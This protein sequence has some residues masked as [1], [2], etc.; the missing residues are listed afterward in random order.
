MAY[1]LVDVSLDAL[2]PC[3]RIA[4][5]V[6]LL[7]TCLSSWTCF[8]NP[9]CRVGSRSG[10]CSYQSHPLLD[11]SSC[12]G[13]YVLFAGLLYHYN[14]RHQAIENVLKEPQV[15]GSAVAC[16][17]SCRRVEALLCLSIIR[18]CIFGYCG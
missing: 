6:Y 10:A 9:G 11:L 15:V 1:T 5:L 16:P 14:I 4:C 2:C 7:A 13:I 17:L 18:V 12:T 3:T 8:R